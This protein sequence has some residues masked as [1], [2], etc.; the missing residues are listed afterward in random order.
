M[1]HDLSLDVVLSFCRDKVPGRG[2]DSYCYSFCDTAGL[3]GVFDGCG[4]S[5]ARTHDAYSGH[6]EAYVASRLCA[7]AFYDHFRRL[8][9]MECDASVLA[10][11]V[12]APQTV[13][14]LTDYGPPKTQNGP[15]IKGAGVRT[16]P[17][18]AAAALM[19]KAGDGT[20]LV[21][22]LWAGDSRVYILDSLGLAQLTV[23]DASVQD[24]M[25]N[26]YEDGVLRNVFCT[27]RPV[28]L[29]CRTVRM[30]EPFAVLTATDGCFGYLTT[31]ME[32]EGI[33]LATL[34]KAKCAA[35]WEEALAELI[36]QI[37]GDDH[38]LCLAA[39]G[40]GDFGN[41]QRRFSA[42]YDYLKKYYLQPVSA[43][44]VEDRASR[45]RLW[46]SY[47]EAYMRYIEGGQN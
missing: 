41:L 23:D 32:F 15:Q 30:G 1:Q 25:D 10:E 33:L 12:F 16:M 45:T 5:G 42:R 27:D 28:E 29:H 17:S 20:V 2:E 35:E 31:P 40:F 19:Q 36:G 46:N 18:T 9:P 8:F 7:G 26:L 13:K 39:Y 21:S 43:M 6:T 24:P 37:A 4:G 3:L 34:L 22:A 44:P 14:R 47:R 11:E 38:T